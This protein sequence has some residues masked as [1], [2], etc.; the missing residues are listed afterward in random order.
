MPVGSRLL[1]LGAAA[2]GRRFLGGSGSPS[3]GTIGQRAWVLFETEKFVRHTNSDDAEVWVGELPE[4]M[5]DMRLAILVVWDLL[6]KCCAVLRCF[7]K[8]ETF[9][10]DVGLA[11]FRRNGK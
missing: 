3:T 2:T 9:V 8:P 1:R 5:F 7:G 11:P 4:I 10:W 6:M